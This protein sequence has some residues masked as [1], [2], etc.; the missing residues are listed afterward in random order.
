MTV[1]LFTVI[2]CDS[3]LVANWFILS[4]AFQKIQSPPKQDSSEII[5]PSRK[6]LTG[7]PSEILIVG[8]LL[9][10]LDNR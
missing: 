8:M 2:F 5:S 10:S 1:A 6:H 4:I 3:L 7:E 9:Y